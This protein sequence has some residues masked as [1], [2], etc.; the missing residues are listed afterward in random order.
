MV[1]DP[2]TN[3]DRLREPTTSFGEICSNPEKKKYIYLF[4]LFSTV[5]GRQM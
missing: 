3:Q 5:K 2:L 4:R 1:P